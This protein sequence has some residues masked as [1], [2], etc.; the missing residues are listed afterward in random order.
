MNEIAITI[1]LFF[2]SILGVK[3]YPTNH[4]GWKI[5]S[6]W[7]QT[8]AGYFSFEATNDNIAQ[9][10]QNNPSL[11]MNYDIILKLMHSFATFHFFLR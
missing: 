4:N 10:C 3:D 7:E 8:P 9:N 11:K 1:L 6:S 5:A 2:S